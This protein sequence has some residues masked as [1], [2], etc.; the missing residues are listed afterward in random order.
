MEFDLDELRTI[1]ELEA[2]AK[3]FE[4]RLAELDKEYEGSFPSEQRNEWN[5]INKALGEPDDDDPNTVYGRLR[6]KRAREAR[7]KEIADKGGSTVEG[8]SAPPKLP[9][10]DTGDMWDLT[11]IRRDASRPEHEVQMLQERAKKAV[12]TAVFPHE[13]VRKEDAQ[14][15]IA[16]LLERDDSGDFARR[17]LTTGSPAYKRAFAK[18]VAGQFLTSEEERALS[19]GTPRAGAGLAVPFV[20]DPTVIPISNSAVNPIRAIARVE[21]ITGSDEWRGITATAITAQY[22]AEGAATTDNSPTIAQ[23]SVRVQRADAF[24]PFSRELGQDW[25]GF[26]GEMAVLLGEAKDDL[27]SVQFWSGAG[28]T[29]FPQGV[30]TGLTTTERVAAI[31]AQA[32]VVGDLYNLNSGLPPRHRPRGTYMANLTNLNRIRAFDTTGTLYVTLGEDTP[33]QL[34]GRRV[35]ENSAMPTAMTVNLAYVIYGDF[36]RYLIL[37]RIGMEVEVIPNMF[38]ATTGFPTGQ[39]GLLAF[40]RNSAIVLDKNAFRYLASAA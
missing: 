26:L 18:R 37:D 27:E 1:A 5:D 34:Q 4:T 24:V 19:L 30:F 10:R 40:W 13:H 39:R 7:L 22:R 31:T 38:D 35:Y 11:S 25:G 17:I 20:L 6:E 8:P 2:K 16:D 29:V 15:R 32:F 3:E 14:E 36:S 28:T 12:D 21:T 9:E 23:P 33:D